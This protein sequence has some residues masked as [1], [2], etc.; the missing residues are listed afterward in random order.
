MKYGKN[1]AF[2][3]LVAVLAGGV[4]YWW[5][6]GSRDRGAG[7]GFGVPD[8]SD[9]ARLPEAAAPSII[10]VADGGTIELPMAPVKKTF[11]GKTVTMLAYAGSIPGPTYRVAQGAE[12]TVN[13][14][15]GTGMPTTLHTHGVRM[16]NAFDG[17]PDLT[18]KEIA[19]G[20]SFAYKLKFPD[21]GAFW[22]H[23]HVRTDYTL[24]SGLYG[25]VIVTPREAGYWPQADREVP[26]MLDDI[27]LDKEGILPF[28]AKTADHTLM[29]R[30]GNVMLVNGETDFALQARQGEVVRL[31]LTNAANTRLFNFAIPGAR[32]KLIGADGGRYGQEAFVDE[33]LI[34]PGERRVVDVLFD[35]AGDYAIKH[36]TPGKQYSLGT[37]S[38]SSERTDR[39]LGKEFSVLRSN[40][41]TAREMAEL[42]ERHLGRVPD[43]ELSLSLDMNSA[44]MGMLGG[45]G[46]HMGGGHMM[47]DGSMMSGGMM[48][49]GD[50]ADAF[51]WEDTMPVMNAASTAESLTWKLVDRSTGR[52]NMDIADWRFKRGDMAKIRIFNDPTSMHPMQHPIHFHGQRF[53]VLAEN[54]VKNAQPVWQDTVLIPKGETVDILLEASNPG[55][56]MTHCH[57]L[58]HAESGMMFTFEVQ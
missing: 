3:A 22:Y 1:I 31:Y 55:V 50:G 29:G 48:G 45:S 11:R 52:E 4:L 25:A 36:K 27:A 37:V 34:A 13:L 56:W 14:K 43:K 8:A 12:I 23:P 44:M 21:A 16:D 19:P 49:V 6:S 7:N 53:M 32:M 30:F 42:S 28:S 41:D 33:I 35:Q 5:M 17:V 54:G 2:A 9:E 46:G 26:L 38:V 51:E 58:E 39:P 15:N 47:D 10:D 40:A 57:I 18:Q 20:A 24:E